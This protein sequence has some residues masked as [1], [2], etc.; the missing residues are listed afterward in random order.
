MTPLFR[1]FLGMNWLLV[2]T[3]YA[4]IVAG[5]FAI[6]SAGWM[7]E[8]PSL[9]SAW[10][11]QLI[12]IAV[13]TVV[14]FAASLID[15]SWITWGALPLYV[16]GVGLSIAALLGEDAVAGHDSWVSIGPLTFQPSQIAVAGGIVL[17]ATLLGH[18]H[19]SSPFFRNPFVRLA[20]TGLT[21]LIPFGIV[22]A[23][24]DFGTAMVWLPVGG[25]MLLVGNIPFRYIAVVI[26]CGLMVMPWAYFFGLKSHQKE[27]ITVYVDMLA[28]KQV[29][30][31][32]SAYAAS[33]II[34]A[35]GSGGFNGKG[36]KNEKTINNLG[37]I[38]KRTA[39]ND[40]IFA[41][42]AEEWG[43]RGALAL[44]GLYAFLL[45]QCLFVAIYSR[46]AVGRL[47]CAGAV[48]L[49]FAHVFQHIGMN[50]LIMPITGIPLPFLSYGGT[51]LIICMFLCG[52]VQS[53]WVH[54]TTA[55]QRIAATD[56]MRSPVSSSILAPG[57]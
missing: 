47:V 27:R 6:Y 3:M 49:F 23:Q 12:W 45:L 1:K 22:L 32:G 34:K 39:I 41:V 4:L 54:R 20:F 35:V 25:A 15:Y 13:G 46:D 26:L 24:G 55:A 36:F 21:C 11:R 44:I 29:D 9:I 37:F 10:N 38:P 14:F 7:K 28:G 53:V 50:L 48:G 42:F 40:F 51:F 16:G 57:Y 30:T 8:E 31:Q 56:A 5:V 17:L 18:L 2:L 52:I 43:F 19:K 33:F